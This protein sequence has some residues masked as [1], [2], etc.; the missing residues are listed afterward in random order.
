MKFALFSTA[1]LASG[2]ASASVAI[3]GWY[4]SAFGGYSYLS[5]NVN[6]HYFG[7]FHSDVRYHN[8][9][10]AGGRIGF[11]SNPIRYEFE[12][13]YINATPK[14]YRINHI[15]QLGVSG[16]ATAN[17]VM[18][19][20]YYDFPDMLNA[21]S[22]F[23]GVGIGYAFIKTTLNSTGPYGITLFDVSGNAFAYQG[24][25]GLTYNFSESYAINASYRY[26]TTT[27]SNRFGRSLQAQMGNVGV[28]Y[29]FDGCNYI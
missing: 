1:L 18:A 24:T 17:V 15:S 28:I 20:L 12:Y 29:R 13:T 7:A 5:S 3:D 11:Q 9:Y 26:T 19:N 21:I 2:I 23:L 4:L 10:N 16:R 14:R 27:N 6:T 25:A 8:G 22:P